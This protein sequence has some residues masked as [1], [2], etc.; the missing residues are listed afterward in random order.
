MR[1]GNRYRL[2]TQPIET[3]VDAEGGVSHEWASLNCRV[4]DAALGMPVGL[5][6]HVRS[7]R[8]GMKY[9]A[10]PLYT[11]KGKPIAEPDDGW[12]PRYYA[13]AD[14]VWRD[15]SKSLPKGMRVKRLIARWLDLLW[16]VVGILLGFASALALGAIQG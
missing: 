5:V 7:G 8:D 6:L 11:N 4:V 14:A 15:W 1:I 13:A 2:E 16:A 12:G 9:E 10:W 3:N